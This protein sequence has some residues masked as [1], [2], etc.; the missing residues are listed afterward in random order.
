MFSVAARKHLSGFLVSA[1]CFWERRIRHQK[2]G[3][4][5]A[6]LVHSAIDA[7]CWCLVALI[8]GILPLPPLSF[9]RRPGSSYITVLDL[10]SR[11]KDCRDKLRQ[12]DSLVRCQKLPQLSTKYLI[13]W[14]PASSG[15]YLASKIPYL[16][17]WETG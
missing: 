8:H 15:L 3:K 13:G 6:G 9:W 11:P 1:G 17:S 12:R 14:R 5:V 16:A 10:G 2:A 4:P 7:G